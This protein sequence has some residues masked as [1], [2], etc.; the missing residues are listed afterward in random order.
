MSQKG[1]GDRWLAGLCHLAVFFQ[2]P[3]LL[4][5][6]LIYLFRDQDDFVKHHCRQALSFQIALFVLALGLSLIALVAVLI[7]GLGIALHAPGSVIAVIVSLFGLISLAVIGLAIFASVQAFRGHEY[8]YPLIG[9]WVA[10]L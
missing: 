4:A 6:F 10:R 2:L 3:G 9:S 1:D 7:G 5:V 8:R